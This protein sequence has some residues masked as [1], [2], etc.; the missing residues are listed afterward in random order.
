MLPCLMLGCV[1]RA[2]LIRTHPPGARVFLDGVER[3]QTPEEGSLRLSFDFYG[4]REVMLR[5]S[6]YE[7][8]AML[9]EIPPPLY[10]QFPLDFVSENLLPWTIEDNH[11]VDVDL[12][13]ILG[14]FTKARFEDARRR[15]IEARAQLDAEP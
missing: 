6:G 15:L 5:K 13:P 1:E 3:G 10:E 9:V 11:V 8:V 14:R 7:S 12:T 4:T 2:I